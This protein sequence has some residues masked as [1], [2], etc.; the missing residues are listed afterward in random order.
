[1]KPLPVYPIKPLPRFNSNNSNAVQWSGEEEPLHPSLSMQAWSGDP[2][3]PTTTSR[4][5]HQPTA[6]QSARHPPPSTRFGNGD[7]NLNVK[8]TSF[9]TITSQ[10]TYTPRFS[11][12]RPPPRH[13][14]P[15]Q[16]NTPRLPVQN[17]KRDG[18]RNS[19]VQNTVSDGGRCKR[20]TDE[21]LSLFGDDDN[22]GDDDDFVLPGN[23]DQLPSLNNGTVIQDNSI[24][25]SFDD[26]GHQNRNTDFFGNKPKYGGFSS[27]VTKETIRSSLSKHFAS[28]ADDD[29]LHTRTNTK[30]N[31][32]SNDDNTSTKSDPFF[33]ENNH[34]YNKDRSSE[35]IFTTKR[36]PFF[37]NA[38]TKTSTSSFAFNCFPAADPDDENED[39]LLFPSIN[40]KT[41]NESVENRLQASCS[42]SFFKNE[43]NDADEKREV[44]CGSGRNE[45][46][47]S[48]FLRHPTEPSCFKKVQNDPPPLQ[49]QNANNADYLLSLFTQSNTLDGGDNEERIHQHG[50]EFERWEIPQQNANDGDFKER[51]IPGRNTITFNGDFE[52]RGNPRGNNSDCIEIDD[53]DWFET[54]D[55]VEDDFIDGD[56]VMTEEEDIFGVS[57]KKRQVITIED[58][59]KNFTFI[60]LKI[61]FYLFIIR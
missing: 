5:Q 21:I 15:V 58:G 55:M 26:A 44:V 59:K 25:A 37:P 56:F 42:M 29:D 28:G 36:D 54:D 1:M 3:N 18:G 61:I 22:F 2:R 17:N 49:K 43:P 12:N 14:F 13:K 38:G 19:V 8:Q 46:K 31:I 51:G 9:N 47:D 52:T 27:I 45:I 41:G 34:K 23:G 10:S 50:N 33:P 24:D 7:Y 11:N 40:K 32:S 4:Q 20:S 53:D 6:Q 39:H 60:K 48:Y 16:N 35:S 57:E 30:E